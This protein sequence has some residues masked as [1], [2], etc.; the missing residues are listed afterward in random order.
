MHQWM[1][2][3]YLRIVVWGTGASSFICE[4]VPYFPSNMHE[5]HM[6]IFLPFQKYAVIAKSQLKKITKLWKDV[7]IIKYFHRLWEKK[8]IHLA[9]LIGHLYIS[10]YILDMWQVWMKMVLLREYM[11]VV[12]K[13]MV[14]RKD[15]WWGGSSEW[16]GTGEKGLS[17]ERLSTQRGSVMVMAEWARA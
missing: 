1:Q 11:R 4:C 2:T 17:D 8:L 15:F 3:L 16:L 6:Y 14:S 10:M 9:L 5:I 7:S 12:L 13:R